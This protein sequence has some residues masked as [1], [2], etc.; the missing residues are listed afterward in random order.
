M[1]R[2]RLPVNVLM[3]FLTTSAIGY[4]LYYFCPATGPLYAFGNAF[5]LHPPD[6]LTM[7]IQPLQLPSS[8]PRNAMPSLHAAAALLVFWNSSA[9]AWSRGTAN[10]V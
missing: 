5:P 3:L 10:R 6:L 7:V 2:R 8:A 4:Q 9:F 1:N